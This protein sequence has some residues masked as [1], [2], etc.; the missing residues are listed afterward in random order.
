MHLAL[1]VLGAFLQHFSSPDLYSDEEVE[2]EEGDVYDCETFLAKQSASEK[3][4]HDFS[5]HA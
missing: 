2:E 4:S 1:G 5:S 3:I